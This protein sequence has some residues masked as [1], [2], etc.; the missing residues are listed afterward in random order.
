M[1]RYPQSSDYRHGTPPRLGVLLTNLGTPEAPTTAALRRY[2]AEFLR[3]PRVVELPRLL[4]LPILH[5]I[6]LNTRPRRSAAAYR[7]VWT[8]EGSPL[9]VMARR[10]LEGV[11]ARLEAR[12]PGRIVC[13]LGMR[14]GNPS[15]ASAL[16]ALQSHGVQRLLV[17]PLYPQYSGATTGSTFDAL[18]ATFSRW[19]WL[20]S[21]R[22]PMSYHAEPGYIA[23]LAASIR[24]HRA[25]HGSGEKLL[26]SFHGI[27]QSY[28]EGGDPYHCQC[29]MT[30]RLVAERL[31]LGP[32]AWAV[33][34]QSRF[35]PRAWLRPYTDETV[36][37]L[38]RAGIQ[39]LDVVAP[40]FSADCLETL[41]ELAIQNRE[42]FEAAGGR[43]LR[44]VP[45]L[46]D[47]PD[48]LDFLADFIAREA[49][50][51][52]ELAPD[53]SAQ[54]LATQGRLQCERAR[55]LGAPH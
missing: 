18:A 21:L 42:F 35:G 6:I 53:Y 47:R 2:L 48:H 14:Y 36:R 17:L 38:A 3:D 51:W 19:R 55:A 32:E 4:W 26:F 13:A 8:D 11:R 22:L 46:N 16:A 27:P 9:L 50:G 12:F 40:G 29:Q 49:A 20:P 7:R 37:A 25:R 15:I 39:H 24:E 23:A 5:G 34:F 10:Q 31:G 45:A 30:A 28:F 1:A 41:E 44:Y 33:S 43:E 52:P 54:A